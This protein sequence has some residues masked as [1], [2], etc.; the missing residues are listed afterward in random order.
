MRK[1]P[2]IDRQGAGRNADGWGNAGCGVIPG[3]GNMSRSLANRRDRS[4]AKIHGY[5][6]IAIVAR[7]SPPLKLSVY[8]GVAYDSVF[9]NRNLP[10]HLIHV[11]RARLVLFHSGRQVPDKFC[12]VLGGN[13][14]SLMDGL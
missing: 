2:S 1:R 4:Q 13:P 3:R 6:S 10:Q 8:V 5:D 12:E 14:L 9:V 7:R 11:L